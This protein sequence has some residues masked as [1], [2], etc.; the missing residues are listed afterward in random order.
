[1]L[2]TLC[3]GAEKPEL[4]FEE[5]MISNKKIAAL[6]LF[7]IILIFL[8]VVI[9]GVLLY[10]FFMAGNVE[11]NPVKI[12]SISKINASVENILLIG[13]DVR[14][15]GSDNGRNDLT[16]ILTLDYV[17]KKIKL[18][19]ILRDCYVSVPGHG[20]GRI[21]TAYVHG[22]PALAINTVNE[23]FGLDISRYVKVDFFGLAKI[24]DS[25]G[26][27]T[28]DELSKEEAWQIRKYSN[29]KSGVKPGKNVKLNGSEAV[30]YGRIRKI[31]SDFQRTGRQRDV[32]QLLVNKVFDMDKAK[33]LS[34]MDDILPNLETNFSRQEIISI[35][36]D[37]LAAG[38]DKKIKQMQIPV[39]GS[40]EDAKIEGALVLKID[41]AK[42]KNALKSFIYD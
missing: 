2:F 16:M 40:Y 20:K 39:K 31:D 30:A 21:N 42:N 8:L 33:L 11:Y 24:I 23:C 10:V 34:R 9:A 36:L 13:L 14:K 18:A 19:S 17:H 5:E 6:K 3:A 12:K 15:E 4:F 1:M 38:F 32:F 22:G 28:L 27:I 35:A 29:K 7:L 26:G 37:V 25:L 41:I